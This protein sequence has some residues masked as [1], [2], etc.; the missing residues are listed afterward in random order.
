MYELKIIER[1][2]SAES[3]S[4]L[5]FKSEWWGG[6]VHI[7]GLACSGEEMPHVHTSLANKH[8]LPLA[9]GKR[10]QEG[11]TGQALV[12]GSGKAILESI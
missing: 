10:E 6:G 11:G 1:A 3:L 8:W 4:G 5:S 2:L 12:V 7:R 9:G